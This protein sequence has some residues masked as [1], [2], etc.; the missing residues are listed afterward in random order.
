MDRNIQMT[1]NRFIENKKNESDNLY[2]SFLQYSFEGY[3]YL[4]LIYTYYFDDTMII[5]YSFF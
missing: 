3:N 5:I 1:K 2:A 4:K